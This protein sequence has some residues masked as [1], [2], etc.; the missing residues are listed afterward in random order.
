MGGQGCVC[1]CVCAYTFHTGAS[2][3][4]TMWRGVC[5]CVC[6]MGPLVSLAEVLEERGAPLEEKE[7]WSVLMA[8]V[9]SLKDISSKGT[10]IHT[11][12]TQQATLSHA[13]THTY[14]ISH[15]QHT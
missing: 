6:V 7:V 3:S 9:Q 15:R 11:H 14:F 1:V 8:A 2:L 10:A 12:N 13:H 5:V 4:L